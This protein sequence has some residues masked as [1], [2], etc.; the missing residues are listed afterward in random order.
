MLGSVRQDIREQL[1][2][3]GTGELADDA[4]LIVSEL[5]GNAF[6][7]GRPPVSVSLTL[8]DRRDRPCLRIGV[9]DSGTALNV[10]LVRAKWRHPSGGLTTD[11]RGLWLV[12]ALSLAWGDQSRPTGHTVWAELDCPAGH[13][14]ADA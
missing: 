5:L 11:G 9:T 3:W 1:D 10:D 8:D 2:R 12:D 6:R 14:P 7:H 13:N 4:A